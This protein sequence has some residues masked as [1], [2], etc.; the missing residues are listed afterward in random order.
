M[1]WTTYDQ[2]ILPH[3][4]QFKW[5][6]PVSTEVRG[7]PAVH[8]SLD[9]YFYMYFEGL[10]IH[11]IPKQCSPQEIT[12]KQD[13]LWV[14]KHQ[15][16]RSQYR[17]SYGIPEWLI[18]L[19]CIPLCCNQSWTDTLHIHRAPW[20]SQPSHCPSWKSKYIIYE[21]KLIE[22]ISQCMNSQLKIANAWHIDSPLD[23]NGPFFLI[24]AYTCMTKQR[25][26]TEINL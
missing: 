10:N 15:S 5:C 2:T 8:G 20:M 3:S 25:T 21:Y 11:N 13:S 12:K 9:N 23:T 4:K 1:G 24:I 6:I 26:R 16:K 14:A 7:Q 19:V 22:S 18:W 17:C